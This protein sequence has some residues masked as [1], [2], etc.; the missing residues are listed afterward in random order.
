MTAPDL[1]HLTISDQ[2]ELLYKEGIYLSKRK[3]AGACVILCQFSNIY[4]EIYYVSYR[5]IVDFII[6]SEDP[7][8]LDP[9]LEEMDVNFLIK[10][11]NEF[12]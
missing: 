4:V 7:S 8:I 9:Y 5:K 6:Y 3:V 2:L 1:S 10:N 12:L 11:G